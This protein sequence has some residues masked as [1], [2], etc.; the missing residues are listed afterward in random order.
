MTYTLNTDQ[1]S[2]ALFGGH[3]VISTFLNGGTASLEMQHRKSQNWA[4]LGELT[5]VIQTVYIPAGAKIRIT[6]TGSATVEIS[7]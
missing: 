6:K 2:A 1:Q 4:P 5:E 3:Y 7:A